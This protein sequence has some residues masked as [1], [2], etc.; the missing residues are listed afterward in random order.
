MGAS[1]NKVMIIGNLGSDPEV[2]QVPNGGS[3]ASFSVAC[4]EKFKDKAGNPQEKTEWIKVV[5]WKQLA[6][7]AGKYLRKGS[8]VYIEG[9]MV[10]RS[11][12]DPKSKE[13]KYSTEVVGREMKMLGSKSGGDNSGEPSQPAP[14]GQS[15]MGFGPPPEDD[16]PF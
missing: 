13:K 5:L 9:K 12:E 7:I 10:T 4:T 16:L 15:D 6:D 2:R 1:L 3:V 11:W 8:Q 14:G